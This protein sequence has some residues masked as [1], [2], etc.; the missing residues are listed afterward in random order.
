MILA[1]KRLATLRNREALEPDPETW[2]ITKFPDT[3]KDAE[4]NEAYE[5]LD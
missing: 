3:K 1:A 2:W 4:D 5:I